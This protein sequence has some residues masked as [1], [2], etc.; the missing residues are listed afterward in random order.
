MLKYEIIQ[1]SDKAPWFALKRT[2]DSWFG[3]KEEFLNFYPNVPGSV[4][5]VTKDWVGFF[6]NCWVPQREI[7]ESMLA[8]LEA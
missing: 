5:W 4:H 6:G 1:D 8:R 3:R 2:R 7:A